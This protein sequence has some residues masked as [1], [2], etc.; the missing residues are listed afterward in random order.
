[1]WQRRSCGSRR[2]S[3]RGRPP[4][5]ARTEISPFPHGGKGLFSPHMMGEFISRIGLFLILL[6][7]G[8]L[9]LF[10]ASEGAGAANFDYL[11]WSL[12][13]II[14]GFFI[15]RRRESGAPPERFSLLRRFRNRTRGRKERR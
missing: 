2:E 12:L 13:A 6:G 9:I 1:M 7:M 8:I 14:V 4:A 15:R 5:A 11:F 10:I 3:Q